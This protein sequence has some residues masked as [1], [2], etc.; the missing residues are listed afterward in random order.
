MQ[1][2]GGRRQV[3]GVALLAL[4]AAVGL[5]TA[6]TAGDDDI[7]DDSRDAPPPDLDLGPALRM[8]DGRLYARG[9]SGAVYRVLG[10]DA[11]DGRRLLL[12]GG[13]Q[14]W[15]LT[16]REEL[17]PDDEGTALRRVFGNPAWE[18]ALKLDGDDDDNV[19][20]DGG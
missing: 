18:A 9:P 20:G 19:G 16:L 13:G 4:G 11:E 17:D 10:V 12:S 7:P 5:G 3:I 15:V 1:T 14:R 6:L 2:D 8:V